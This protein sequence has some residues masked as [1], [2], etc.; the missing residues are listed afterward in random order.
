MKKEKINKKIIL[1]DKCD[2][3][4][5]EPY[6]WFIENNNKSDVIALCFEHFFDF[7]KSTEEYERK[8]N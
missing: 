7:A 8:R 3:C 6:G 5:K 1:S 4:G 2:L